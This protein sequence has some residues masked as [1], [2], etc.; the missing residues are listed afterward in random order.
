MNSSIEMVFFF[1]ADLLDLL[2]VFCALVFSGGKRVGGAWERG[3]SVNTTGGSKSWLGGSAEGPVV[4]EWSGEGGE[5]G[6][7]AGAERGLGEGWRAGF[8]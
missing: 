4:R 5:G 1:L 6:R 8:S 3:V 2:G 7:E